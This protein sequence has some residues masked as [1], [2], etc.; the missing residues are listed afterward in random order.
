[1]VVDA[2]DEVNRCEEKEKLRERIVP[3]VRFQGGCKRK[4]LQ[5]CEIQSLAGGYF[6]E[7]L[8]EIEENISMIEGMKRIE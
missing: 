6:L 5:A 8:A 2:I 4:G 3:V 7:D 1:M